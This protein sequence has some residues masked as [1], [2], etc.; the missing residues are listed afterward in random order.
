MVSSPPSSKAVQGS[1]FNSVLVQLATKDGGNVLTLAEQA[2]D[3]EMIMRFEIQPLHG[4]AC[5]AP[6]AKSGYVAQF[7]ES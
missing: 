3:V 4:K 7:P 2:N 1:A 5:D 6:G